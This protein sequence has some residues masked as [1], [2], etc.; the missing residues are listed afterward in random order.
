MGCGPSWACI[1][2]ISLRPSTRLDIGD[3]GSGN[4]PWLQLHF[5]FSILNNNQFFGCLALISYWYWFVYLFVANQLHIPIFT[6]L[7]LDFQYSHYLKSGLVNDR[8]SLWLTATSPEAFGLK[9]LLII[10]H[11]LWLNNADL[12]PQMVKA[13]S[14]MDLWV[15]DT[16]LTQ[17]KTLCN[18]DWPELSRCRNS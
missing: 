17:V 10:E 1:S 4:S 8:L 15:Q 18:Q 9:L 11:W 3:A 14:Q 13:E 7:C 12:F 5:N 16:S 2:L 6:L